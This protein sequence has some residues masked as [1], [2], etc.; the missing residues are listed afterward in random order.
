MR[1]VRV[2]SSSS[3]SPPFG[4]RYAFDKPSDFVRLAQISSGEYFT[5]PLLRYEIE[6]D[7]FY[8]DIDPIY[9]RYVSD[10][11]SWGADLS[12]WPETFTLWGGQ[13]LGVQ[14]APRL[15]NEIDEEKLLQKERRLLA[16]ARSKD[17]Q[18]EPTRFPPLSSWNRARHG[19]RGGGT[20]RDRGSRSQLIG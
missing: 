19:F 5:D 8:A 11:A 14:I 17:A 15:K 3:V 20:R 1:S 7:Y 2:D 6:G 12:R 9:M 16:D 10:D 13:W 4:Y 18:Q